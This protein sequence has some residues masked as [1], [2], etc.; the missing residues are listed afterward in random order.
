[1]TPRQRI[2][3]AL[4]HQPPDRT[5]TDGWFH[6]EVTQTL[7]R[8]Y[9]T[10]DWDVVLAEL[11]IEGW[12]D[13]SAQ[14]MPPQDDGHFVLRPGYACGEPD[15]WLDDRTYEDV[16]GVRFRTGE[17]GRYRQW[18]SGP[19]QHAQTVEDL[20][21]CRMLED[22]VIR[23]P[24]DDAGKDYAGQVAELKRQQRFVT[25]DLENPFRRYW[26]LRGLENALAD[27]AANAELVEAVF[28]RL[29]ALYTEQAL[30]MARAGVDM[31]RIVG[32]IAMQDRIMMGPA[33]WRRF[34]KPRMARLIETCRAVSPEL[35]FFF[36]SDGKLTELV[37][38]LIEIGI[39]VLNPIQPECMD[40]VMVKRRWGDRITLHGC[41]SIQRTLPFGSPVDV[42]REVEGLIRQCGR[43]GGLILMPSNNVQPDT[44]LENVIACY[45]AARDFDLRAAR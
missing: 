27:Y 26:N 7:K 40:P 34:D 35:Y 22:A 4:S 39:N 32:D 14:I 45:H 13:L 6:P 16:W 17:D 1:M 33:R 30:R 20:A 12:A 3:T 31:V 11:G 37:D 25:A 10:D 19:L 23:D 28:D 42:R 18:L 8:H 29:F 2:L 36:H 41:I 38:D 5:P 21:D 24:E 44:P 43:D 9:R 15:R